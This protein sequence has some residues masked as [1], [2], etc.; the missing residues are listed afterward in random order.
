MSIYN[1]IVSLSCL[2][3]GFWLLFG[4]FASIWLAACLL[5]TLLLKLLVG[6]VGRL[7]T[8]GKL[9]TDRR[10]PMPWAK[11]YPGLACGEA[12]LVQGEEERDHAT[13]VLP[14]EGL[15]QK[16]SRAGIRRMQ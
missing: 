12:G 16:A 7:Y 4:G 10:Q 11:L 1:A 3:G 2:V 14:T 13:L 9:A 5:R 8:E 6:W 15:L